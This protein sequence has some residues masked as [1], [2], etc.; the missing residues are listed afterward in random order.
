MSMSQTRRHKTPGKVFLVGAGTGDPELLTIKAMRAIR[1]SDVILYDR[2]V[3]K[4]IRVLFPAHIP[5]S[6]ASNLMVNGLDVNA[7][8]GGRQIMRVVKMAGRSP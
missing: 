2:L 6:I 3:S 5:G 1:E 4:E 7:V 8:F